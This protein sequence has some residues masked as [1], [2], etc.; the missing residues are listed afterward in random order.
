MD[1][2]FEVKS[3]RPEEASAHFPRWEAIDNNEG[4]AFN[5]LPNIN[6]TWTQQQRMY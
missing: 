1:G 2:S 4:T 3:Q 6:I 5:N